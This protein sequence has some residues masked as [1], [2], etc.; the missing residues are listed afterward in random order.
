MKR[1]YRFLLILTGIMCIISGCNNKEK[2]LDVEEVYRIGLSRYLLDTL[3]LA[4]YD[5]ELSES[6]M[7]YI[8]KGEKDKSNAQKRDKLGL[9]YIY[10]RNELH[11]DRLT[12]TELE[13]LKKET[14]SIEMG[15][16][17]DEAMRMIINTFPDVISQK[18]IEKPEDKNVETM[19]DNNGDFVKVDT[20]VLRIGTKSE[21][22]ENGYY[23]DKEHEVEKQRALEEFSKEM[24]AALNGKIGDIPIR[25]QRDASPFSE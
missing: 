13:L 11:L 17:S 22:D 24:E 2:S 8:P 5:K 15:I 14:E 4:A 6:Q 7:N 1:T 19:Y 16:L 18:Q 3:D 23:V 10:L 9:T 25:V 12:E 21:F 20:L